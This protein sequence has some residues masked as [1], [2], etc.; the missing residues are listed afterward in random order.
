M[1]PEQKRKAE[2]ELPIPED[3]LPKSTPYSKPLTAVSAAEALVQEHLLV[4]TEEFVR[5]HD[6]SPL[7]D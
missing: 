1:K 7:N 3:K 4:E 5:S 6:F 2:K